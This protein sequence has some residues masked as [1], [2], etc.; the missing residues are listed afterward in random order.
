MVEMWQRRVEFGLLLPVQYAFRH[1]HPRMAEL[2]APQVKPWAE[3]NVP[4][5]ETM[6][7]L[8]D[9]ELSGRPFMAGDAFSVAD[10]TALCT[11]DFMRV[12]RVALKESHANLKRWH[13][14]VS[15]RP[16]AAA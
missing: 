11:I 1:A 16:S 2:E 6:L 10:I 9:A 12:V 7:D 5:I 4:K 8:L 3:A 14:E 15:A 13:A